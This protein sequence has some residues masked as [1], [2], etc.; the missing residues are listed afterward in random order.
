MVEKATDGA[1]GGA[2]GET[3]SYG[4]AFF[5]AA[6]TAARRSGCPEIF[7]DCTVRGVFAQSYERRLETSVNSRR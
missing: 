5:I 7:A 1:L 3:S 6:E 4:G 2:R